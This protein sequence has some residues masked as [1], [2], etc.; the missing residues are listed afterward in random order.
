VDELRA[1]RWD[2]LAGLTGTHAL[3]PAAPANASSA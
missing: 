2:G 1:G 3:L